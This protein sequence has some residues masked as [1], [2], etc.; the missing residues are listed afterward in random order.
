M[1][2]WHSIRGRLLVTVLLLNVFAVGT[3]TLYVYGARKND[4][5]RTLDAKLVSAASMAHE[6][7]PPE[8]HDRAAAGE[9]SQEAFED[10]GRRLHRYARASQIEFV[11]TLV[12]SR[13]GYR[14]VLDAPRDEEI[15]AGVFEERA[16]YL[17][18]DPDDALVAAFREDGMRFAE[19]EDGWGRHRSVFIPRVTPAGTRYVAGADLSLAEIDALLRRTLWTSLLIGFV[20]FVLSGLFSYCAVVRLLCPVGRARNLVRVITQER[21]LT[22][23]AEP[24]DDEIGALLRDFNA[25]LD[26]VQKLVASASDSA[27]T[28]AS[29]SAQ[30]STAGES[31]SSAVKSNE[32]SVNGVIADGNEAK[33]LLDGMG[34]RL[35]GMVGVVDTAAG[36]L[37]QSRAQLARVARSVKEATTAQQGLSAH[38]TQ[39][40]GEAGQIR[41]VLVVIGEIAEQTNLLALNSAIEAARAGEYGRG[42]TVVADEVRKLAERTRKSLTQTESRI[43]AIMQS[44]NH[45]AD[46]TSRG[47]EEF[48]T[49]LAETDEA[50]RLIDASVGAMSEARISVFA[51][52]KDI[53][54]A[55]SRTHAVLNDVGHI[56]EQTEQTTRDIEEI[57]RITALL[58]DMSNSLRDELARF[59]SRT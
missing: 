54:M 58:N 56:G 40:S 12:A 49:M 10:Y 32:R 3:Y 28:T 36:G 42:F 5:M 57:T 43:A 55:L 2:F 39:L 31:I 19:Y 20:I 23:R 53:Q 51:I 1:N 8:V 6:L 35:S 45:A 50:E 38:L 21:N 13:E 11:Y 24:G 25:M 48:S 7:A 41:E 37:E 9:L 44:I 52:L 29:V 17:Y 30:L 27:V 14:F 22:L 18:E 33:G 15:A 26:E 16:L 46:A 4:I 47:A 34:N 59:V